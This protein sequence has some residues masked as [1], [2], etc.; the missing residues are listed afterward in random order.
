MAIIDTVLP[1]QEEETGV[2][3]APVAEAEI[4]DSALA[5][6]IGEDF[7]DDDHQLCDCEDCRAKREAEASVSTDMKEYVLANLPKT[8]L[9]AA[10][11]AAYRAGHLDYT[12]TVRTAQFEAT[13]ITLYQ[14]PVFKEDNTPEDWVLGM[15]NFM[16]AFMDGEMRVCDGKVY[17]PAGS[18]EAVYHDLTSDQPT[19]LV[20]ET[21]TGYISNSFAIIGKATGIHFTS[22]E[23]S[24]NGVKVFSFSPALDDLEFNMCDLAASM[25]TML[26]I[27]FHMVNKTMITIYR[28]YV[29]NGIV[30]LVDNK[31]QWNSDHKFY[32]YIRHLETIGHDDEKFQKIRHTLVAWRGVV[33]SDTDY[34]FGDIDELEDQ[35]LDIHHNGIELRDGVFYAMAGNKKTGKRPV[36]ITGR[37]YRYGVVAEHNNQVANIGSVVAEEHGLDPVLHDMLKADALPI[38]YPRE[39]RELSGMPDFAS[40]LRSMR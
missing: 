8:Q 17:R 11:L 28:Q 1:N 36:G 25:A 39:E 30:T 20:T 24:V 21:E 12:E 37:F 18:S 33:S 15:C 31:F 22:T 6:I 32:P 38:K 14:H 9:A 13:D 7:D 10:C 16:S 29:M 5:D 34:S 4:E 3:G 27:E 35:L 40:M 26:P 23:L 2:V 19:Q